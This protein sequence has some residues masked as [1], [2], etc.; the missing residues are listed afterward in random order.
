MELL[1]RVGRGSLYAAPFP[2]KIP[3]KWHW[4][5]RGIISKGQDNWRDLQG[6]G[7]EWSVWETKAGIFRHEN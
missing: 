6:I 3:P 7:N 2:P 4:S 1:L 5:N